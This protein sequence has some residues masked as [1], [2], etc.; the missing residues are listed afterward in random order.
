M[1]LYSWRQLESK[2]HLLRSC[3]GMSLLALMSVPDKFPHACSSCQLNRPRLPG[4]AHLLPLPTGGTIIE[5][6]FSRTCFCILHAGKL[7][8]AGYANLDDEWWSLFCGG[9]AVACRASARSTLCHHRIRARP[10][11]FPATITYIVQDLDVPAVPGPE[12]APFRPR[13]RRFLRGMKQNHET[14]RLG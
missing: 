12:Q 8:E 5:S 14:N 3:M 4:Q 2:L 13:R 6:T 9:G 1:S 7:C 10:L 11:P